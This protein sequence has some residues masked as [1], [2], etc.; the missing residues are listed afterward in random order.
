MSKQGRL[1]DEY[2]KGMW[3]ILIIFFF[4]HICFDDAGH[5]FFLLFPFLLLHPDKHKAHLET[6]KGL[7]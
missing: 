4:T 5:E 3:A 7:F 2:S 1:Q 6:T